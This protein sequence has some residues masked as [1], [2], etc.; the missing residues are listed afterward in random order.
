MK[1]PLLWSALCIGLA[2]TA[3]IARAQDTHSGRAVQASGQAASNIGTSA[4]HGV[5]ASGQAASGIAAVPLSAAGVVSGVAGAASM[6]AA[7]ASANAASAPLGTT[8]LPVTN[9]TITV[10]PPN[11]ALKA[12]APA[13]VKP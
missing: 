1:Q 13:A 2:C 8:P 6:D 10:I 4:A 7:G 3:L 11:E 12:R 5:A 9:E